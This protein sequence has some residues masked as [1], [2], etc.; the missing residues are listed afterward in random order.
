[1]R[2]CADD[3]VRYD[4]QQEFRRA[5]RLPRRGVLRHGARIERRRIRVDAHARLER[6]HHDQPDEQGRGRDDFEVQQRL[7]ADP[8]Q[9]FEIADA[10]NS[11]D[12]RQ[13]DDRRNHHLDQLDKTVAERLQACAE[14]RKVKPNERA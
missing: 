4:V 13:K 9:P 1:M 2:E 11:V 3:R 5:L 10:G 14:I 12:D 7:Q 6:L 8:A